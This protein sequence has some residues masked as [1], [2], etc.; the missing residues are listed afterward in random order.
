MVK[1]TFNDLFSGATEIKMAELTT[2]KFELLQANPERAKPVHRF[3][4]SIHWEW[5]LVKAEPATPSEILIQVIRNNA[6][7]N[8]ESQIF[9]AVK[10]AFDK[11]PEK[12]SLYLAEIELFFKTHMQNARK[13][14]TK[15]K[16]FKE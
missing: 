12:D 4:N 14:L 7:A 10:K 2:E 11:L 13:A 3:S 6:E 15:A 5:Q 8:G 1:L 16:V 9:K